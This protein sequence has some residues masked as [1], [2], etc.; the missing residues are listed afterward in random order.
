MQSITVQK[1]IEK[2]FPMDLDRLNIQY[3][4]PKLYLP[5]APP[6]AGKSTTAQILVAMGYLGTETVIEPDYYRELLAGDRTNQSVNNEVFQVVDKIVLTRLSH[7]LDVYL[8]AT[9]LN[10]RARK[11]LLNKIPAGTEVIVLVT[12]ISLQEI[13]RR[14]RNR[15]HPVS[16]HVIDRMWQQQQTASPPEKSSVYTFT[17]IIE[18]AKTQ[19]E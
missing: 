13:K 10:N 4:K 1:W 2:N 3:K 16:E 9:N 6:A 15:L 18:L 11:Q 7:G 5:M 12:D 17:E 19:G 8:D 14:N